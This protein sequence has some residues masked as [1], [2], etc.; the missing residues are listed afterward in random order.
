M[1]PAL[2]KE[3]YTI[4]W[5]CALPKEMTAARYMLDEYHGGL[6]EQDPNDSNAYCLG[7]ISGHNVVIGCLPKGVYGTTSA[8]KVATNMLHTFKNVRFGLLVGIGGGVPSQTHDIRLGDVVV[9]TPTSGFGGVIQHDAG[10]QLAKDGF[11]VTGWLNKPPDALLTAVSRLETRHLGEGNRI[12][13]L[14]EDMINKYPRLKDSGYAYDESRIDQLFEADGEHEK[15]D[16]TC[17]FCGDIRQVDRP[18]RELKDPVVHY[19]IMASGNQLMKDRSARDRLGEKFNVLCFETEAAGLMDHLP[20]LVIRGICDYAD[21]HKNDSWQEYAAAAAAAY[22][23]EL[24]SVVP[25]DKVAGTE[26]ATATADSGK[27]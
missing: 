20:A 26:A 14:I 11:T 3:Q 9:S 15:G 25:R 27:L 10:K 16:A 7:S 6:E 1:M 8:A 5:I 17:K 19:G 12:I 18:V 4:G 24:L 2:P 13:R 22:A 23:K 21:S